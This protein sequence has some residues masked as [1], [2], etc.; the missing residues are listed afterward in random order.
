MK[1]QV[2]GKKS[3]FAVPVWT[4][5]RLSY[6]LRRTEFSSTMPRVTEEQPRDRAARAPGGQRLFYR[7]GLTKREKQRKIK[8]DNET[9]IRGGRLRRVGVK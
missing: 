1:P 5:P 6:H 7:R 3:Y 9:A 2:K 8:D 4:A